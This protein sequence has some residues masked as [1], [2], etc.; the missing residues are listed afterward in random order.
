MFR[1]HPTGGQIRELAIA[2]DPR[3]RPL[4]PS[5]TEPIAR[6]WIEEGTFS[7]T[8][9]LE[10]SEPLSAKTSVKVSLLWSGASGIGNLQ[11]PRINLR[12]DKLTRDWT[13]L[14][15][16][17]GL[18]LKTSPAV[19][20]DNPAQVGF[21][22]AWGEALARGV[23]AFDQG[24][25]EPSVLSTRPVE[26]RFTAEQ[27]LDCSVSSK[28]AWV[29][30]RADLSGLPPHVFV[31][32]L[33]ASAGL[34]VTSLVVLEGDRPAPAQWQQSADGTLI[35]ALNQPPQA[36]QRLELVGRFALDR[37]RRTFEAPLVELVGAAQSELTVNIYRQPDVELRLA[38]D[39][40]AWTRTDGPDLGS[41]RNGRGRLAGVFRKGTAAATAAPDITLSPNR[42]ELAG[43]LLTRL[44]P[45]DSDWD[46][47][48]DCALDVRSGSLDALRLEFP[49]TM[50]AP[51]SITPA[52]DHQL[53]SVPGQTARLLVI[54][55]QQAVRGEL[56]L[57]IRGLLRGA[58]DQSAALPVVSLLDARRVRRLAALPVRIGSERWDWETSGLQ[59]RDRAALGLSGELV[60]PGYEIFEAV[61][62]RGTAVAQARSPRTTRPRL[63][64]AE[65][66]AQIIDNGSVIGTSW[67][68]IVPQGERQVR[69]A[70]PPGCR[71]IHVAVEGIAAQPTY[72]GADRWRIPTTSDRLPQRIEVVYALAL[73]FS[74]DAGALRRLPAVRLEGV[75]AETTLWTVT[76]PPG[77]TLNAVAQVVVDPAEQRVVRL[78]A[79]A[80]MLQ[81]VAVAPAGDLP[82]SAVSNSLAT[83]GKRL[84]ECKAR[85]NPPNGTRLSASLASRVQVAES[86]AEAARKQLV[87][88]GVIAGPPPTATEATLSNDHPA[89]GTTLYILESGQ[90]P[91]AQILLSEGELRWADQRLAWVAGLLALCFVSARLIQRWTVR[92]WVARHAHFILA[93]GGAIWLAALPFAWVG[94]IAL[95]AA[96]WLAIRWPWPQTPV[97][98]PSSLLR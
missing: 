80:R 43:V 21:P 48:I 33:R 4:P 30:W 50:A 98:T 22:A 85:L 94:W 52:V 61:A 49:P 69:L 74:A 18:E 19:R 6:Q 82:P 54:R 96:G 45:G 44:I 57:A 84:A 83:W 95:A 17:P 55:P 13:A 62:P 32:K 15:L 37:G 66:R 38:A 60:P 89:F 2:L 29:R 25:H 70:C 68:D 63:L 24:Q 75:P 34:E 93:A 77:L 28:S 53:V 97:D 56:R 41:Y 42:P 47:E 71:L 65:H 40:R 73:P 79:S 76:G 86:Q 16:S 78:E 87:A 5:P 72:A 9:H 26:S 12:A 10:L 35:V 51:L 64:L 58:T 91:G 23:V 8:L 27:A 81:A 39:Q 20:P 92:S 1:I 88:G 7:S 36:R 90:G 14:D 67:L 59:S 3:L 11:L 46:V 31:H